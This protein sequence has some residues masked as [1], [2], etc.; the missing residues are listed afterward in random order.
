MFIPV[1]NYDYI[2]W[3]WLALDMVSLVW[4][5]SE[6]LHSIECVVVLMMDIFIGWMWDFS[7]QSNSKALSFHRFW[8]K[9]AHKIARDD[10]KTTSHWARLNVYVHVWIESFRGIW[11]CSYRIWHSFVHFGT[12][13]QTFRIDVI[14]HYP[15][16][17]RKSR[18]KTI[19]IH[20]Q[21]YLSDA[22]KLAMP[23]RELYISL[24]CVVCIFSLNETH[25]KAIP[26]TFWKIWNG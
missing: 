8:S 14:I 24:D 12:L 11:R 6:N 15:E 10:T 25:S 9:V 22:P 1:Y 17:T 4:D 2:M 5:K 18:I 20:S 13:A 19:R 26:K 21:Q 3:K 16:T 23:L 7:S